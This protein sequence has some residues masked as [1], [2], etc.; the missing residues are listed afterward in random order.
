MHRGDSG[1]GVKQI[2]TALAAHG[3][4]VAADGNFG[5]Q[6]EQ[7][8]K[9]FQQKNGLTADGVVGPLTWAK[10][11]AK[12]STSTTAKGTSTTTAK[13]ATTTT[14]VKTTTTTH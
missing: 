11:Q 9:A 4:Q 5:A 6:T 13:S 14:T 7:A 8:V 10:L 2:Q 12:S 3:Y 1:S